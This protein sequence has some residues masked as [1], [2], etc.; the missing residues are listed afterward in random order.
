M[1]RAKPGSTCA[2]ENAYGEIGTRTVFFA[3]GQRFGY[4]EV[5]RL[6]DGQ[7]VELAVYGKGPALKPVL[8]FA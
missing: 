8:R 3:K 4:Q 5:T 2:C 6:T 7:S 1:P